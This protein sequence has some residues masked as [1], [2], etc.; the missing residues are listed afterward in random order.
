[1]VDVTSR[2][3]SVHRYGLY[4]FSA[5][6]TE[7]TKKYPYYWHDWNCSR[8]GPWD[9]G[10]SG[11]DAARY[12][13]R[14]NPELLS[15]ATVE[16]QG[17]HANVGVTT[18]RRMSYDVCG[19]SCSVPRYLQGNPLSMRR[20]KPAVNRVVNVWVN[21]ACSAMVKAEAMF[22]RGLAIIGLVQALEA[23]GITTRVHV[24]TMTDGGPGKPHMHIVDLPEPFDLSSASFVLAHPAW[25]R[26]VLY[27]DRSYKAGSLVSLRP[28][29]YLGFHAH[30][31]EPREVSEQIVKHVL[32]GEPTDIYIPR[33]GLYDS[34]TD[35]VG[36]IKDKLLQLK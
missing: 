35:K 36:W 27:G 3:W 17:I 19:G 5:H 26:N 29:E 16:L 9:L 30:E 7:M 21:P 32:K 31:P 2:T 14:G 4:E 15:R 33:L 1:M 23:M 13:L 11:A 25:T 10:V 8:G 18:R 12:A 24:V 34:F 28:P 20:A 22:D 6:C